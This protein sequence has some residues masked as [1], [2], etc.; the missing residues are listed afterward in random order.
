MLIKLNGI[1]E[2]S[3]I[4]KYVGK[5][6]DALM[7]FEVPGKAGIVEGYT[8]NYIKVEVPCNVYRMLE[9]KY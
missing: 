1:N 2:K 6:M 7:E 9:V 5:E 4:E 8:K 3:F